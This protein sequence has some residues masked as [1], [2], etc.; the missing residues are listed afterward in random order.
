MN[1]SLKRKCTFNYLDVFDGPN[2]NFTRL[3]NLC[4][5]DVDLTYYS[6]QNVMTLK[7]SGAMGKRGFMAN[8][9]TTE[10]GEQ[11]FLD[12]EIC[13]RRIVKNLAS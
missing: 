3:A 10:I 13:Y 8:Y 4:K 2:E 9:T 6:T 7:Y 12:T 5:T 11:N 1:N